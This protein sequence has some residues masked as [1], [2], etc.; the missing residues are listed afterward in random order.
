MGVRVRR[1]GREDL[2]HITGHPDDPDLLYAA[3]GSASLTPKAPDDPPRHHGGIAR[4]R[5]GGST[6]QR[7]ETDYTRATI[8]PPARPDLLL[9]GPAPRVG[10]GGPIVVS[11]DG[12]ETWQPAGTGVAM[13]MP[14]MVELFVA[15]PDNSVWA[16][17]SRRRLLRAPPE[18]SSWSSALPSDADVS[19]NSLAFT[20]R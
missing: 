17:C 13:P 7:L 14:D 18:D 4:S 20:T 19:V 12:G 5:D 9:A 8:I 3:L 16:I 10:R 2:H 1:R 11:A 6:W 15:A